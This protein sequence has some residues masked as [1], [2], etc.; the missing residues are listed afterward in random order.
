MATPGDAALAAYAVSR[1]SSIPLIQAYIYKIISGTTT[2]I[3]A[4]SGLP[5]FC[6]EFSVWLAGG[7]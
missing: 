6:Y 3:I 1:F 7:L 4:K 2:D 5:L